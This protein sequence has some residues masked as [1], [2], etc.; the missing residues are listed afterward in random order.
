MKEWER[1]LKLQA[2]VDG[3]LPAA[4]ARELAEALARDAGQQRLH[5]HL[6]SI[7]VLVRENETVR[8]VPET[9]E[10]YWSQIERR[11]A[12]LPGADRVV[13]RGWGWWL[14]WLVPV[15]ATALLC[16]Y[17]LMPGD[18]GPGPEAGR[19]VEYEVETPLEGMSSITFRSEA[20]AMTV[21]WVE[22]RNLHNGDLGE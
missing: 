19:L 3:E 9:R 22:T 1:Q 18:L 7:K 5:D 17:W 15:G 13:A 12:A 16:A 2:Y 10:F 11:L 20:A 8:P 14:R 4:E 21:V 6:H